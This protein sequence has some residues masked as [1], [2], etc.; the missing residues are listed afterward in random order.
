MSFN[1]GTVIQTSYEISEIVLENVSSFCDLGITLDS[2]LNFNLHID[3]CISKSSSVLGFI[4]RWS[5][6]FDDPYLPKRLFTSLVRPILE[7]GSLVWSPYYSCHVIELNLSKNSSYFLH[8]G[9]LLGV[10]I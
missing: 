2:K 8:L 7:Y 3:A 5:R 10:L 4:K 9:I 6:E 1:R